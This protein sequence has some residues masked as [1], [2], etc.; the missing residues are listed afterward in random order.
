MG[1]SART[2]LVKSKEQDKKRRQK[3]RA[4]RKKQR[5]SGKVQ[6]KNQQS[7]PVHQRFLENFRKSRGG[8]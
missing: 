3:A 6:P 5:Q 1:I 8:K 2:V 7:L 4:K